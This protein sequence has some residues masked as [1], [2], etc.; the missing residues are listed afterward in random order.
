[1]WIEGV[2]CIYLCILGIL[3]FYKREVPIL[4][5][6]IG[7]VLLVGLGIFQCTGNALGGVEAIAGILPGLFLILVA[8]LTKKAGYG[9]GVVLIQLG[10]CLGFQKVMLLFCFSMFLISVVCMILLLARKVR[11]ETKMPYLSFLAMSYTIWGLWG[12]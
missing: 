4:L 7:G 11:K 6:E 10:V 2:I 3:D 1:M 5:L 9:D 12:G 8:C